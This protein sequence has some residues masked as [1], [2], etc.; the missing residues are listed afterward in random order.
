MVRVYTK[1]VG[2][3]RE[4]RYRNINYK[5]QLEDLNERYI[6]SELHIK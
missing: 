2:E 6:K 5:I 3:V 1:D 4:K